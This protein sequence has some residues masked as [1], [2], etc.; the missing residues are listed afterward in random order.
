MVVVG[1]SGG[2]D[3]CRFTGGGDDSELPLVMVVSLGGTAV[4]PVLSSILSTLEVT[5][6]M[7]GA[8]KPELP[9]SADASSAAAAVG[10]SEDAVVDTGAF[11]SSTE[12]FRRFSPCCCC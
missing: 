5:L 8:F 4:N 6:E 3:F 9:F 2:G 11:C 12:E 7:S 10:C 1:V